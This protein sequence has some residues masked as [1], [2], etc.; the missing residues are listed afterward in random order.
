M[1]INALSGIYSQASHSYRA[2]SRQTGRQERA[3]FQQLAQAL[4]SGNLGGA[5]QAFSALDQLLSASSQSQGSPQNGQ[6]GSQNNPFSTDL[7]AVGQ[8]L[9]SGDLTGAQQAFAQ[10]Q[11]DIQAFLGS[12][13]HHVNGLAQNA[14][15]GASGA[16]G[17][18]DG[19]ND[20]S[21]M[22]LIA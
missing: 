18:A 3:D 8:A 13:R 17:N 20:G 22:H 7:S 14:L 12:H 2:N 15:P 9:K 19:D 16:A 11:K 6:Q 21:G 10:L 1:T 4:G 5:Q